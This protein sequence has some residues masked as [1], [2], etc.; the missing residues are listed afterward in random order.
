MYSSEKRTKNRTSFLALPSCY[1]T[2]RSRRPRFNEFS[3]LINLSILYLGVNFFKADFST[4]TRDNYV[5]D[6]AYSFEIL[7]KN[8]RKYLAELLELDSDF[9]RR[10]NFHYALCERG[11]IKAFDKERAIEVRAQS[12]SIAH[13]P[14]QVDGGPAYRHGLAVYGFLHTETGIGQA[15]RALARAFETT[16]LPLSCHAIQLYRC[17]NTVEFPASPSL[18]SNL[19]TALLAMNADNVQNIH[20]LM[21]PTLLYDKHRIGLFFWELPVFPTIWSNAFDVLDE[22]W[23]SSRYVAD[24]MKSITKKPIN[25]M[26][27]PIPLNDLDKNDSRKALG[28]PSNRLIYLVNFDFNS[29]PHRKNPLAAVR[30]FI[31]AF[32]ETSG[33]SP[34]LIVKCHGANNRE[35]YLPELQAVIS[36]RSNVMLIDRVMSRSDML[37]LQA[38]IDVYVSLH[39][40]EGFGL[41]LAECM[42]AGKL[43]IGTGFSGNVDFMNEQNSILVDY[44]MQQVREGEYVEWQGQ[45]WANPRHDD[46]VSAL[47]LASSSSE[48]RSRL[49]EAARQ[50]IKSELSY[51]EVGLRMAGY[52]DQLSRRA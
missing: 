5:W 29:F 52:V 33:F 36:S 9:G 20:H 22:I 11:F 27:L 24:G 26:P 12:N 45:W 49:G 7:P 43:V 35:K 30:A 16:G 40:S 14:W 42:A 50:F 25:I 18:E 1:M 34:I 21:E 37:Q 38:A 44:D 13:I 51:K 46:A 2:T 23:V 19:D 10:A 15:G 28:L 17:E 32:P 47:R 31:D 8:W 6:L 4:E 39:R 3:H 48:M 41:N